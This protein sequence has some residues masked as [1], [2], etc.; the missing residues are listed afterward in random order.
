MSGIGSPAKG[1]FLLS[2]SDVIRIRELFVWPRK[3]VAGSIETPQH[4]GHGQP[5]GKARAVREVE[6]TLTSVGTRSLR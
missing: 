6:S 5:P 1:P 2:L 3:K 4:A